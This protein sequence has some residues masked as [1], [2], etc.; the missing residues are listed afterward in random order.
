MHIIVKKDWEWFIAEVEWKSNIF[1]FWYSEEEAI[2]E[3]TNVVDM[4]LDYYN[5]EVSTQKVIKNLLN[6]KNYSYA[7]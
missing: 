5:Q 2:K 3:L 7:V 1:A 4:M 6:K